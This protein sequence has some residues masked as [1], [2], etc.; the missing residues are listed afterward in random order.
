[1]NDSSNLLLKGIAENAEK[2]AEAIIS[3]AKVNAEAIMREAE[4]KAISDEEKEKSILELKKRQLELKLESDKN[5]LKRAHELKNL[6]YS[7]NKV[8]AFVEKEWNNLIE[9]S[10]YEKIFINWICEAAVGLNLNKAKVAFYNKAPVTDKMLREAEDILKSLTGI[11][12]GLE[13]DEVNTLEFGVV[14]SSLDSKISY[15]NLVSVRSRRFNREI[16]KIIQDLVCN[17][18]K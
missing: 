11:A 14:L 3:Q 7:Y 2:D 8:M 9:S 17:R 18:E 16:K 10:S 4:E 5:N 6:D 1:M 13:L 12:I 15:N